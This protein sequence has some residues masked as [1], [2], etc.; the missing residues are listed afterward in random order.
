MFSLGFIIK[1]FRNISSG[2]TFQILMTAQFIQCSIYT[3]D[4]P[5]DYP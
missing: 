2:A 5:K 3:K 1:D 4:Q